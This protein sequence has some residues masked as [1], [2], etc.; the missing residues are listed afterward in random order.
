MTHGFSLHLEDVVPE[1]TWLCGWMGVLSECRH[2]EV[3]LYYEP[4]VT[5]AGYFA[6]FP[7]HK[8]KPPVSSVLLFFFEGK[9]F[10]KPIKKHQNDSWALSSC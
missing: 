5:E 4:D 10:W 3:G 6:V 8:T 9:A 2:R 1:H 7:I